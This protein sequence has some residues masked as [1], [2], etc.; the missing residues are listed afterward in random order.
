MEQR[1]GGTGEK[2]TGEMKQ[3]AMR[4]EQKSKLRLF[5]HG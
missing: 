2:K 4:V 3:E 1:K 5:L